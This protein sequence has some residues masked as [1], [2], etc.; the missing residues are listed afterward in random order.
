MFKSLDVQEHKLMYW[1]SFVKCKQIT[2][3]QSELTFRFH[4]H[5]QTFYKYTDILLFSDTSDSSVSAIEYDGIS[6]HS[7]YGDYY[8]K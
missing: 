7:F 8:T 2:K 6:Q 4:K 5:V 3:K 1:N